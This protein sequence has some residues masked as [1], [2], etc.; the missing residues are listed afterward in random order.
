MCYTECKQ[1]SVVKYNVGA[2][3]LELMN[4]ILRNVDWESTLGGLDVND[5]WG[6]FKSVYQDAIDK[7]VP[8]YK[9][10]LR[11]KLWMTSDALQLKRSE[12]KLWNLKGIV[13]QVVLV[14]Y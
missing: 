12:N 13:L 10:K 7:C 2:A 11:K 1:I 4:E 3:N 6:Y 9:S 5:S 14:I 8:K